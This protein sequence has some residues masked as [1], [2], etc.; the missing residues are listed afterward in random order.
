MFLPDSTP[1][2]MHLCLHRY[3]TKL[4]SVSGFTAGKLELI[5]RLGLTVRILVNQVLR[6]LED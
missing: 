4:F 2:H 5:S 6:V 1:I 3:L